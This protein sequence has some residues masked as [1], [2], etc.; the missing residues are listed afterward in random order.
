MYIHI[1]TCLS[2]V[3]IIGSGTTCKCQQLT[4]ILGQQAFP[5]CTQILIISRLLATCKK[6]NIQACMCIFCPALFPN[7]VEIDSFEK[8]SV[9]Q[10]MTV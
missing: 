6:L 9:G 7:P 8:K 4:A 2:D 3:G 10:K 5:V 1:F